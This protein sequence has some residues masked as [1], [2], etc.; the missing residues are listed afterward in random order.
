[1]ANV[2]ISDIATVVTDPADL[3][4]CEG[5]KSDGTP[6]R[7]DPTI[8]GGGS[9]L[10]PD[11]TDLSFGGSS[12]LYGMTVFAATET[13]SLSAGQTLEMEAI[14]YGS[15]TASAGAGSGNGTVAAYARAQSDG[16]MVPYKYVGSETNLESRSASATNDFTGHYF[17]KVVV[18]CH[19]SS[20]FYT[21]MA[22][23]DK[24]F[25]A[26]NHTTISGNI[27][28][29][30]TPFLFTDDISKCYARARLIG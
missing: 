8:L 29:T 5:E 20:T 30:Q 2:K 13:L 17:I 14:V 15:D 10:G 28:G 22:I 26:D 16:N 1:M 4:H 12:T 27:T 19:S 18:H 7:F 9:T 23:D 25:P 11:W 6:V 21:N 3:A 24:R